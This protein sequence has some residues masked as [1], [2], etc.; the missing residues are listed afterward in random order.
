M[1]PT[2]LTLAASLELAL[3][4]HL[5]WPVD[6]KAVARQ[7]AMATVA[8]T[9]VS[10]ATDGRQRPV[11]GDL[12]VVLTPQAGC[13]ALEKRRKPLE[14]Q[15]RLDA[16]ILGVAAVAFQHR[17][18]LFVGRQAQSVAATVSTTCHFLLPTL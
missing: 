2:L 18:R 5:E 12:V 1:D 10:A 9:G 13:H 14:V 11:V 15:R 17:V 8:G 4:F 3:A 6:D 7:V 16:L